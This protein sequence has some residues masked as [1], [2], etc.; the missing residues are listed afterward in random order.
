MPSIV[1]AVEELLIAAMIGEKL[2]PSR[3]S[4]MDWAL[5]ALSVLLGGIGV[6]LAVLGL[7]RFLEGR[8]TPDIAALI[9]AAVVLTAALLAGVAAHRFRHRK[10]L[11]LGSVKDELGKNIHTLIEQ[12]CSELDEPVRENPKTAVML[13]A[14]AGFIA[15]RQKTD[16]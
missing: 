3:K 14:L 6:F 5:T 16:L 15:A 1:T 13:A 8:Y 2:L 4:K 10:A 7:N 12:I 9:A 11:H